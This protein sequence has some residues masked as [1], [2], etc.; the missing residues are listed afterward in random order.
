[1][2][3]F[4]TEVPPSLAGGLNRV[5]STSSLQ[6]YNPSFTKPLSR[7]FSTSSLYGALPAQ[8][9]TVP[10]FDFDEYFNN[11]PEVAT[12]EAPLFTDPD[13]N[14]TDEDLLLLLEN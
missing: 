7:V 10:K 1:M 4:P 6:T 2:I 5:A 14:W 9:V 3:I 12:T 11:L 8:A 13:L